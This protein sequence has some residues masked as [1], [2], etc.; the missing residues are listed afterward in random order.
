MQFL[1]NKV[2]VT[3]FYNELYGKY[4][5]PFLSHFVQMLF[6]NSIIA[7]AIAGPYGLLTIGIS[8]AFAII[9]PSILVF[10]FIY[11]LL[12]ELG[13][14][15]RVAISLNRILNFLGVNSSFIPHLLIGCSC[16]I[17]AGLK[18]RTLETPKEKFM[19]M[20]LLCFSIP[21]F[22]QFAIITNLLSIIPQQY[23]LIYFLV[24]F[25]QLFIVLR[26]AKWLYP[27][28][29]SVFIT[30]IA[31]LKIASFGVVFQKTG[32]YVLWYVREVVPL[33][34]LSAF[35]LF[36]LDTTQLLKFLHTALA[37]T[38]T[39][40]LSLPEKF[41]ET[42]ILGLI[43][44]DFGAVSIYDLANNGYL[45]SIQILVATT[46]ISLSVPCLGFLGAIR[47]I[48]GSKLMFL[49]FTGSTIY[50]LVIAAILNWL[51]RI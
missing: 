45:N 46:F 25:I 13:Y 21:C 44:K 23:V 16:K 15:L 20:L 36:I 37:P 48:Q 35:A 32:M 22:S 28:P 30:R 9:L 8:Y 7:Q 39:L 12:D 51:L 10:F 50:A 31:P 24:I 29:K 47:R 17:L 34:L 4:L 3:L 18:T 11:A 19:A 49:L 14:L 33:I 43:R 5:E 41:S 38:L 26:L 6:G 40:L 1:A 27:G 2:F 42:V